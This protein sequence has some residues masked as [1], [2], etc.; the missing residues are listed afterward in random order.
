MSFPKEPRHAGG[1]KLITRVRGELLW[2][3]KGLSLI[4]FSGGWPLLVAQLGMN[5]LA[6][7]DRAPSVKAGKGRRPGEKTLRARRVVYA[8]HRAVIRLGPRREKRIELELL[9]M[10]NS[11]IGP[12][13]HERLTSISED[14]ICR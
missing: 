10:K 1:R 7:V 9:A 8:F 5:L 12:L 3:H 14:L 4:E 13:A 2:P 6:L 11:T